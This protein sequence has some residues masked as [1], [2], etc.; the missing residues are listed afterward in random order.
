MINYTPTELGDF[1][2]SLVYGG[3]MLTRQPYRVRSC[4][5]PTPANLVRAYGSGLS[6]GICNRQSDF[7]IDTR[8][9]GPGGLGVT[10]EGP[11]EAAIR[12]RDNGDGT[13]SVFYLPTVQGDYQ[14]N[15]TFNEQPIGGSPFLAKID[16][17][18]VSLIRTTGPGIQRDKGNDDPGVRIR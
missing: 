13:C 7:V 4:P 17:D 3:Q 11:S 16:A 5:P 14:V 1:I 10:L 6:S 12:C 8:A 9:A 18:P 2:V 15:I